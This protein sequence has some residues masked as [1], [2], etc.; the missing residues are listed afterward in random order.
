MAVF[1]L[2]ISAFSGQQRLLVG[3]DQTSRGNIELPRSNV[4]VGG[5]ELSR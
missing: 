3:E 5:E 2:K 1:C 4:V